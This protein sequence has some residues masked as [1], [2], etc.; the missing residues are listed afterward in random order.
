M[1]NFLCKLTRK[2]E[3]KDTTPYFRMYVV[4]IP[5]EKNYNSCKNLIGYTKGYTWNSF[6]EAQSHGECLNTRIVPNWDD[7]PLPFNN[8][9]GYNC[10]SISSKFMD[11]QQNIGWRPCLARNGKFFHKHRCC[12]F[13]EF[14]ATSW[15][16]R[17]NGFSQNSPPAL[18]TKL[19]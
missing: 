19:S 13:R 5:E 10:I 4:V 9:D 17:E 3:V 7:L 18:A 1:R 15:S 8:T 6:I 11:Y 2:N 12:G 14:T 16:F